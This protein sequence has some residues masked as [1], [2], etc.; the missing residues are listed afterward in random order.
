M[1]Y[2]E[3]HYGKLKIIPKFDNESLEEQCKRLSKKSELPDPE[4]YITWQEYLR[5]VFDGTYII[6][7]NIVYEIYDHF[8]TDD[9]DFFKVIPFD[10]GTFI[11]VGSFYNGGTCLNEC[12]EEEM[13]K[14]KIKNENKQ[15]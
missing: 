7:D 4:Y 2:T 10:S 13:I 15:F 14:L 1:S 12:I 3:Y 11:F 6:I 9:S 8:E 5:D